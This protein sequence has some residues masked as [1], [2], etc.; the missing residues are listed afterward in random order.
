MNTDGYR[1]VR[2]NN[3][4]CVSPNVSKKKLFPV[5]FLMFLFLCVGAAAADEDGTAV[6][7]TVY[8]GD[9]NGSVYAIDASDG[10]HIWS[11]DIEDADRID[12]SPL[13]VDGI[14][15]FGT[16]AA[17]SYSEED[18]NGSSLYALD[19]RS[20]ETEWRFGNGTGPIYAS[21]TVVNGTVYF[22]TD[23]PTTNLYAVDSETGE[24]R[25][26]YSGPRD[27]ITSRATVVDG[28]VH[29]DDTG[30]G[31]TLDA[32]SGE[33]RRSYESFTDAVRGDKISSFRTPIERDGRIYVVGKLSRLS[34][35]NIGD[36]AAVSALSLESGEE[37]W[38]LPLAEDALLVTSPPT[39]TEDAIYVSLEN[40]EQESFLYAVNRS[41]NEVYWENSY[42]DGGGSSEPT[43]H[44]ETVYF[45]TSS[46]LYAVSSA[47]GDEEWRFEK[48]ES[49]WAPTVA[50][51][52]VY[53]ADGEMLYAL[54]A[55]S[56]EEIWNTT[57][58][59]RSTPT[60]V[61]DPATGD[62]IDSQV[63]LG[64][65]GHHDVWA[66]EASSAGTD[67]S[68]DV[69]D[70]SV[71]EEAGGTGEELPGFG[72]VA[73]ALALVASALLVRRRVGR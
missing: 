14:V 23:S 36:T 47:T 50:G 38:R 48:P 12:S 58:K 42:E 20:G 60:V 69:E 67:L 32:E 71:S 73:T 62:S 65:L 51:G 35:G 24:E 5:I 34:E 30:S 2:A 13:V 64:T 21:P 54:D 55:D 22:G 16:V 1:L 57:V 37:V 4:D 9:A 19:A 46:S 10:T 66:E 3:L 31:F 27:G 11:T 40:T 7:K 53:I 41:G 33:K 49:A 72:F 39:V 68:E 18:A 15:Y 63:M 17:V 28:S 29:F 44:D 8:V 70:E 59:A 61:E 43:L 6:G 45:A 56:G 52:V 26:S 25:W